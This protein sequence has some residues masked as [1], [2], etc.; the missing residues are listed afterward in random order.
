MAR[1]GAGA[2]AL[3]V[4]PLPCARAE[5]TDTD[6]QQLLRCRKRRMEGAMLQA[7]VASAGIAPPAGWGPV[8]RGGWDACAAAAFGFHAIWVNRE[9]APMDRLHG[10]PAQELSDLR[11]LPGLAGRL[12][13]EE[14]G[15]PE[16]LPA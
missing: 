13:G 8:G 5:M 10:R 7:A 15:S 16:A 9:G 1:Q 14:G 2:G 3:I 4:Q 12:A 11:A 6:V